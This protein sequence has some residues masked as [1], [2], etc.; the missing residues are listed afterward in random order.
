MKTTLRLS[1]LTLI[2]TLIMV[3]TAYAKAPIVGKWKT[4]D[5][6]TNE[7][8]SIVEIT[9]RGGKYY[10]KIVKLFRKDGEDPNPVCDECED[11]DDRKNKPIIGME[12]I[13]DMELDGKKYEGGTILDPKDGKVYKCKL[14]VEEDN[15]KV[16]GYIAFFFKTQDWLPVE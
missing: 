14:W 5:D 6:E 13:R 2:F 8:K 4:I 16:R 9:E 12:I 10:G 11:D 15:L 7:A 1:T 3:C